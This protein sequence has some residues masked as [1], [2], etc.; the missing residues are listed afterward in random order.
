MLKDT[1]P[2]RYSVP[3]TRRTYTPQFKSELLTACKQPGASI[4]ALALQHGMNANVL[5]RWL[6]DH[7]Q[8][9]LLLGDGA[10]APAFIPID[11]AASR[12]VSGSEAEPSASPPHI[13]IELQHHAIKVTLHWPV[14]A[15][16]ECAQMLRALLR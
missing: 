4:A 1:Q 9:T 12:P 10:S 2:P 15:A 8:G 3:R 13:R 7:R 11:L 6:K 14:D 16:G 5:H